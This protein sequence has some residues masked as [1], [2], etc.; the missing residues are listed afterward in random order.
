MQRLKKSY[1]TV[2]FFI[3]LFLMPTDSLSQ[4]ILTE[5]LKSAMS[6]RGKANYLT[7]NDENL[8]IEDILRQTNELVWDKVENT[9]ENL[10]FT[11]E[12]FWFHFQIENSTNKTLEFYFETGRPII[13]T[14]F[15][16]EVKNGN[17]LSIQKAGDAIKFDEK[18]VEHRKSLFSLSVPNNATLDYYL[19]VKSDGE[20]LMMPMNIKPE[21]TILESTYKEQMFYGFF[22]GLLTLAFIVYLFFY[23]A[24]G[25]STFLYYS[26]YVLF[27]G[28]LQFA[29]DGFFF[30][31]IMPEGGWFY[32]R[33][34]L[35]I[36][37]IGGF[38]L[39][40]YAELFLDTHSV[41]EVLTKAFRF[42]YFGLMLVF[43]GLFSTSKILAISYPL[44]NILG[45]CILV[46]ILISLIVKKIKKSKIDPFFVLGIVS[47]I[48]GYA[49]FIMSNFNLL[50]NSFLAANAPK[51]GTGLEVI[52]LSTSMSNRIRL[53][54]IENEQNQ[55]IALQRS[56]DMNKIKSLFL[57][58]LSHELRTP[59]NLI[60][61]VASSLAYNSNDKNTSE[62]Y[63][64]ILGSSE[65]LLRSIDDILSFTVI[66]KGGQF[67]K[68]QNFQLRELL[69]R[70]EQKISQMA[71][72]KGINILLNIEE[73]V[74]D[75]LHGDASKLEQILSNIADN[76]IK[77]TSN[78]EVSI[79][80]SV[81]KR[82]GGNVLIEFIVSDTGVGI[83]ESQLHTIFE[84]FTKR[85]FD[86]K[87][88]FG[89]LG[90]GLFIVK[91]YIDLKSGSI[92]I[93][94]N[95]KGGV[96]CTV[97]VPYKQIEDQANLKSTVTPSSHPMALSGC[98][99]LLIEDNEMNQMVI[100]ML[101]NQWTNVSL[102][103]A[104][105]GLEGI[106]LLTAK[107]YDVILMDIQMPVMDGF[108]ATSGIRSGAA[109]MSKTKTP[110]IA[111]TADVT[112]KTKNMII[113][114]GA[115]DYMNKPISGDVLYHKISEVYKS[116]AVA[117]N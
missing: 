87:R 109:G 12:P 15:L 39:G 31:F 68:N 103:V 45:L 7:G 10:G 41:S 86:D 14:I 66:E 117:L 113:T 102:D 88:E 1:L 6:I 67:L 55:Q 89:G 116:G 50:S 5:E 19:Y 73:D 51:I 22:Y 59:L 79:A 62:K 23:F 21:E 65:N 53:L 32:N 49:L 99:I 63:D 27:I 44:A 30:Q 60:M 100:T 18:S 26:L 94:N 9:S 98:S 16:Y 46:V 54:R 28:L 70:L 61:G 17:L 64:L 72:E 2:F 97:T 95:V 34:V 110:I 93:K 43:L 4:I 74:P 38:F 91:K 77:F 84:S 114:L 85:S 57:S 40:R 83:E 108:E 56:E 106:E 58:N 71:H 20:S 8:S 107:H 48:L 29:V 36:A 111:V 82:E 96:E 33:A 112:D 75:T 90:L 25:D 35:I 24:L 3:G 80:V 104:N 78:G 76:A 52:F 42:L 13:D 92:T 81:K 105:N 101:T 69:H 37:L 115:D 47:L 11:N